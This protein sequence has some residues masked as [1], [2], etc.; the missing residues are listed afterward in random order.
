MDHSDDS[1]PRGRVRRAAPLALLIARTVCGRFIAGLQEATGDDGALER[2]DRRAAQRYVELLGRSRGVLMK[3]GQILSM[4]D[5]RGWGGGGF[6]PYVEAL[7]QLHSQVPMMNTHLVRTLL[8]AELQGDVA[9][10]AEFAPSPVAAA[11]IGQVHRAV[12]RDG[13]EVAV[14][15]QYPGVAEAIEDDLSNAELVA[16]FVRIATAA[17]ALRVD[18]SSVASAAAARIREEVDYRHE[19]QTLTTFGELYRGHPF[20]RIPEVVAEASRERVLAMTYLGG[21]DWNEAQ[22]ADQELKDHWAEVIVRFSYSNRWLAGLLHADPHP[23]NYRFF[24]DGTVGFLDFGCVQTLSDQER[25]CWFAMI[26]AAVDGR[27][28]DLRRLM[29]QAGFLDRDATLTDEDVYQWWTEILHD[30]LTEPQP[31]TYTPHSC[32]RAIGSMFDFRDH[33]HF[34]AR[35]SYP[36]IAV[37][38]ARIQL[39]LTSICSALGATLPIRAIADDTDGVCEPTTPLGQLHHRWLRER[40]LKLTPTQPNA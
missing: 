36:S 24:P 3:A 9:I 5:T 39:N 35:I 20:I 13:R 22:N 31:V 16:T 19:A 25:Y 29:G 18:V 10:F 2:F 40:G 30:I 34:L 33:G 17:T 27:K 14:K 32:A 6:V 38:T 12:L 7:S 28:P 37:M 26:R 11:S 23:N 8:E 4:S 15:I 1:V 21:M